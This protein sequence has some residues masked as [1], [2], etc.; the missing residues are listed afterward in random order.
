MAHALIMI[1]VSELLPTRVRM[2]GIGTIVGL[3]RMGS[4]ASAIVVTT[5]KR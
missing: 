4:S 5:A 3:S 2:I 1:Y